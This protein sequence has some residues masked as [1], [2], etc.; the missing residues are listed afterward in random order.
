MQANHEGGLTERA[1]NL[2]RRRKIPRSPCR[3][4]SRDRHP[5]QR[6]PVLQAAER[7]LFMSRQT[8]R[9]VCQEGINLGQVPFAGRRFRVM[10][11]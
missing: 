10:R 3:N 11:P 1:R 9:G 2:S 7:R 5:D 4:H 6:I 8:P